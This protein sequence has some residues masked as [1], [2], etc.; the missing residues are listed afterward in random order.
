VP[1]RLSGAR[2]AGSRAGRYAVHG[3]LLVAGV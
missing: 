3:L 2:R 1:L